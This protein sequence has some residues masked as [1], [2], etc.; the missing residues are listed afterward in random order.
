MSPSQLDIDLRERIS[1]AI[2]FVDES[3]VNTDR[4]DHYRGNYA[5][6]NQE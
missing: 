5:Q 4:P 1:D 6:E 2:A 3:V